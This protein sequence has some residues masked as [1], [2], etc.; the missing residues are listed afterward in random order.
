MA[1]KGGGKRG[2]GAQAQ[3]GKVAHRNGT[4]LAWLGVAPD[5]GRDGGDQ[6]LGIGKGSRHV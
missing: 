1:G 2:V 5:L 3:L 4:G 6:G